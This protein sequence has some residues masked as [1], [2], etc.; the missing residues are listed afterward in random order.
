MESRYILAID[1]GT[2]STKAL[3]FDEAGKAVCKA[4]EPLQTHYLEGGLVEQDPAEIIRNALA[5][6]AG[7]IAGFREKGR[8]PQH[9]RALAISNQ[10]ETFLVWDKDGKPLCPAIVWQCRRSV[11]VCSRLQQEGLAPRIKEKT[12]LLVDPYFS[13]TKLIWLYENSPAVRKAARRG[14]AFFGTVDTWLLYQLTGGSSY[15]TDLTNASRTLFFNLSALAWDRELLE[16][17]GLSEVRLPEPRPSASHFG[18]S[19]LHGLLPAPVPVAAMI[20]DSH[21]AAFGEGC[22]FPGAAK[23]TLGTGCSIMMNTG[24]R[25]V[26]AAEGMVTTICWSMEGRVD[27]ALEGLIISCGATLEWLKNELGL[28]AS[29]AEI[30]ALAGEVPDNKGVYLVPAFSGLGAPYWEMSRKASITGLSFDC[31]RKHLAR[32]ALESIPYQ[33]RDVISAME[34]ASPIQLKDLRVN[35]GISSSR[36]V[37]RFLAGLLGKPVL[38]SGMADASALGA[39]L[40][41]GLKTDIY[42]SLDQ[43][44]S[45]QAKPAAL[46]PDMDPGEVRSCYGGWL[47]AVGR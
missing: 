31:T 8:A 12:G 33:V 45:F 18:E 37:L 39:A 21:A 17:F 19:D 6:A 3:I 30:E 22:L 34:A 27:Y 13:G 32:A 46:F 38:S 25:P 42:R 9:I 40:L 11:P 4:S 47:R 16:L 23:A 24:D 10:R 44:Q 15:L 7:C 43:L 14:A 2:S 28:F 36:F 35:G 29:I 5:A 41:A 1:Q 20:G 26:Q